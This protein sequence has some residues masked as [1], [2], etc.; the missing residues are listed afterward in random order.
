MYP[1]KKSCNDSHICGEKMII[2]PAQDK[3]KWNENLTKTGWHWVTHRWEWREVMEALGYKSHYFEICNGDDT[4]ALFPCFTV[5]I[6]YLK[7]YS[8]ISKIFSFTGLESSGNGYGGVLINSK[9][10]NINIKN[11]IAKVL[12]SYLF[13]FCK[14]NGYDFI[15]INDS[16]VYSNLNLEKLGYKKTYHYTFL[17]DLTQDKDYLWKNLEKRARNGIRKAKKSGVKIRELTSEEEI[18]EFH[19]LHVETYSRTNMPW[20]PFDYLK[21]IWKNLGEINAVKFF[22]AFKDDTLI[23]GVMLLT[24]G[25]MSLYG[26]GVS[27]HRYLKFQPNIYLQWHAILWSKMN[28]RRYYDLGSVAYPKQTKKE[29]GIF[30]FK[31]S[32]GGKLVSSVYWVKSCTIKYEAFTWLK[33]LL[34]DLYEKKK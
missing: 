3:E 13:D 8:L 18:K 16:P 24:Y 23:A 6:R 12:D 5:K 31:R 15:K 11:K 22:G 26:M 4:I 10:S 34:R 27:D 17:L 21:A 20:R 9:F 19:R 28:G 32:L 29:A 30:K 25:D 1:C 33:D 14:R 7:D 2:R